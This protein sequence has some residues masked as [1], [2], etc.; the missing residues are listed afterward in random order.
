MQVTPHDG[1]Q[2]WLILISQE[3]YDGRTR[4]ILYMFWGQFMAT[5]VDIYIY[6]LIIIHQRA[7][8]V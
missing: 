6:Y 4:K 3:G 1:Q 8:L 5:F 7:T 2:I